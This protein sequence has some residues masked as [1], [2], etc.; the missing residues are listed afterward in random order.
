VNDGHVRRGK[1]SVEDDVELFRKLV[2]GALARVDLH[3]PAMSRVELSD[4]LLDLRSAAGQ[5]I[6]LEAALPAP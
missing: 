5:M 4:L 1:R 3:G 2:D 6:E